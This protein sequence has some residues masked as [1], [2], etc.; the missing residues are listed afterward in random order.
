MGKKLRVRFIW[1]R[2]E[3]DLSPNFSLEGK[4]QGKEL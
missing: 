2:S 3:I 1:Q 4:E